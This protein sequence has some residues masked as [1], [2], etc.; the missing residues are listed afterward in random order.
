L[1]LL[2]RVIVRLSTLQNDYSP[3][4]T[5]RLISLGK[6]HQSKRY[7]D[8]SITFCLLEFLLHTAHNKSGE[9]LTSIDC[10]VSCICTI[11]YAY[12]LDSCMPIAYVSF[13]VPFS[14]NLHRS[15]L[16]KLE[17]KSSPLVVSC[18]NNTS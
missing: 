5:C 13:I 17:V 14:L 6:Q 2:M 3:R 12:G 15:N 1:S 11:Q 18:F 4:T 8:R 16:I 9:Q 7:M 10:V